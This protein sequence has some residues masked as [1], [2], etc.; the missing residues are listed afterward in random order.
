VLG[1]LCTA[2]ALAPLL[3]QAAL[4]AGVSMFGPMVLAQFRRV[5]AILALRAQE[6]RLQD[7][8]APV[9]VLRSFADDE[10]ELQRTLVISDPHFVRKLSLEEQIVAQL[11][12]VGPVV[13]I[14]Q[15]GLNTDPIGAA[16]EHIVGPLWQPRVQTLIEESALVVVVLGR[17]TEGL[18]WEYEQLARRRVPVLVI[19]QSINK[20]T[21]CGVFEGWFLV[22]GPDFLWVVL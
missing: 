14:G 10:L 3:R 19:N 18:L 16:R 11:W 21:S 5:R 7:Q 1:G 9:L 20:C 15:P 17:K 4:V 8:R 6:V 13:A 2:L 12:E 22:E